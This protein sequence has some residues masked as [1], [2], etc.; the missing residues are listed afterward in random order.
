MSTTKHCE[1][2]ITCGSGDEAAV[3]A[4]A[5]V[6]ARLAAC[7]HRSRIAS[8]YEW[9]GE[10]EHDEEVLLTAITRVE[11]VDAIAEL[12]T[13]R[14]SYDLP[15]ITSVPLTGTTAYLA[16]VDAQTSR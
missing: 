2:R 12:V 4:D 5:L 6:A 13:A 14:H 9:E 1:V 8:V 16:W 3:L 11:H 7:V 15:A 10:V